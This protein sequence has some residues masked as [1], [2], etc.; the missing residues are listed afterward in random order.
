MP[1][2]SRP[3]RKQQ[4]PGRAGK[5]SSAWLAVPWGSICAQPQPAADWGENRQ[6]WEAALT[7]EFQVIC[8]QSPQPQIA[9]R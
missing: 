9:L 4:L 1:E 6:H 3:R 2:G 8:K 7:L 5:G